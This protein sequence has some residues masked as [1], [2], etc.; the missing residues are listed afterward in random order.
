[1]HPKFRSPDPHEVRSDRQFS[2]WLFRFYRRLHLAIRGR[3]GDEPLASAFGAGICVSARATQTRASVWRDRG[4]EDGGLGHVVGAGGNG[5]VV[6]REEW[7]A[8][9]AVGDLLAKRTMPPLPVPSSCHPSITGLP[10]EICGPW[11]TLVLWPL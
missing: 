2:P 9:A 1:M 11:R 6:A 4:G 10:C 8:T 5:A 3:S 7:A